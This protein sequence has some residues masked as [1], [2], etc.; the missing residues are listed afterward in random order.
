MKRG[1]YA[2]MVTTRKQSGAEEK[3]VGSTDGGRRGHEG[4]DAMEIM[5]DDGGVE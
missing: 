3:G 2:S 1:G 5:T 4:I